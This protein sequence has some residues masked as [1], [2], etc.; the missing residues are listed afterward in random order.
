VDTNPF[1]FWLRFIF[2]AM[3]ATFCILAVYSVTDG[4]AYQKYVVGPVM[5]TAIAGGYYLIVAGKRTE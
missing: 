1:Q 4:T 5:W 3:T 2:Y